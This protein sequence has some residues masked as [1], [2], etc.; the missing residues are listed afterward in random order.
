MNNAQR[1]MKITPKLNVIA[2]ITFTSRA[3]PTE[4]NTEYVNTSANLVWSGS[5]YG[6]LPIMET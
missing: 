2:K 5:I 1:A 3:L 4:E 6:K